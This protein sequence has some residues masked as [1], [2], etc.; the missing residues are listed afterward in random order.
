MDNYK[1]KHK[2][3][4]ITNKEDPAIKYIAT[5]ILDIMMAIILGIWT[6]HF[7]NVLAECLNIDING[8]IIIQI[9]AI[10]IVIYIMKE[11]A[12]YIRQEPQ[13][14]YSYDVIFISVYMSS[15]ENI[16]LLLAKIK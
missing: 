9:V 15:Q 1:N 12:K 7:V 4:E 5:V 3:D 16:Q 8:K 6:N 11:I 10:S 2:N 14:N 13:S